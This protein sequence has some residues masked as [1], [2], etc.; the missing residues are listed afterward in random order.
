MGRP[1][2]PE[3][4]RRSVE[5]RRRDVGRRP[6]ARRARPRPTAGSSSMCAS[7]TAPRARPATCCGPTASGCAWR[8]WPQARTGSPRLRWRS[9]C[10]TRTAATSCS[11]SPER[12][13]QVRRVILAE[14]DVIVGYADGHVA[15]PRPR[16]LGRPRRRGVRDRAP[17]RPA[18][19]RRQ[20]RP[21]R[22]VEPRRQADRRGR[23]AGPRSPTSRS[24]ATTGCSR[25]TGCPRP[26]SA[27]SSSRRRAMF[28]AKP[29][30]L[31]GP[32]SMQYQSPLLPV[33]LTEATSGSLPSSGDLSSGFCVDRRLG[34]AADRLRHVHAVHHH[35]LDVGVVVPS[36]SVSTL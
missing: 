31:S 1:A 13:K 26:A 17:R 11:S 7:T 19:D 24:W 32:N 22:A 8:S 25:S 5:G 15:V 3:P 20:R 21:R 23:D 36:P 12:G 29:G 2:A 14:T 9:A 34:R 35:R 33:M 6:A 30:F 4:V 10:G 18:G 28:F 27:S 16:G